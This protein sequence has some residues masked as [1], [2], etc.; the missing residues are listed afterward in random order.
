M[1]R[2]F[3]SLKW[4]M[5]RMRWMAA[6]SGAVFP[7]ISSSGGANRYV[8]SGVVTSPLFEATQA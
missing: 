1:A 5:S 3:S 7:K 8:S 4:L 2:V 6:R